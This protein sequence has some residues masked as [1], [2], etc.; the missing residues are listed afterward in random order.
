MAEAQN[1]YREH[2][3]TYEAFNK[4][5]TF[6]ILWIVLVLVSMALGLVGSLPVI[7]VLLGVG[8]TLALLVGFA[9]LG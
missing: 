9:V 6:A 5:M 8:G 4:L 7:A 2:M 3:A 1:E